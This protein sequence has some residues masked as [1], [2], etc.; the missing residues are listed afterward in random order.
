MAVRL[1][2]SLGTGSVKRGATRELRLNA[3]GNEIG[4]F[5]HSISLGFNR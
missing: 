2:T 5:V 4:C 1:L 3:G